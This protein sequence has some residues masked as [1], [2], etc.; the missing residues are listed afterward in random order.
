MSTDPHQVLR[1]GARPLGWDQLDETQQNGFRFLTAAL[2]EAASLVTT[3]TQTRR[4][5]SFFELGR[6]PGSQTL[7]LSGDRGTGKTSLL[8]TLQEATIRCSE[9]GTP[10]E[11]EG[12]N[13]Q[14][15]LNDL[16]KAVLLNVFGTSSASHEI[17]APD[18]RIRAVDPGRRPH[19]LVN[20]SASV[21]GAEFGSGATAKATL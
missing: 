21:S 3:Y 2:C 7:V 11:S 19:G 12:R 1:R 5:R 4:G 6:D 8:M 13:E 18:G 14:T 10:L 20:H 15:T 9:W 16:Q 17:T